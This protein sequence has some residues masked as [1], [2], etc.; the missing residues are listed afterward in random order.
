MATTKA[1]RKGISDEELADMLALMKNSDDVEIKLT[2]PE[3]T[4]LSTAR[5]LNLD[6]LTAQIRQVFFLDTP[7]LKLNK[8]GVV[9]RARR[10]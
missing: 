7:D 6:A 4:L 10:T 8:A 9:V 5:K 3:D 2:L 1:P